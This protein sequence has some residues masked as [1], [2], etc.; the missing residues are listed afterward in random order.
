MKLLYFIPCY[1]GIV[2]AE[3]IADVVLNFQF[4]G[5]RGW[6]VQLLRVDMAG[7]ARA[8]NNAVEYAFNMDADLMLMQ[9]YDCFGVEPKGS[10]HH[11]VNAW[12]AEAAAAVGAVIACRGRDKVNAEPA[13]PG[14]R[15]VADVGTGIMLVDMRRLA[16]LPRPWFTC[17]LSDDG[18]QLAMSDDIGFCRRVKAHGR[19]VI[20][21]Y[22][23][24]TGHCAEDVLAL[25]PVAYLNADLERESRAMATT[26]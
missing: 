11:L 25:D 7:I 18:T 3:I 15:Y 19:R 8:R 10:L 1:R 12:E 16:D 24:S 2:R 14:Q 13:R 9:D 23:F 21:D 6:D 20:A 26:A 17:D 22:T 4:C 5:V